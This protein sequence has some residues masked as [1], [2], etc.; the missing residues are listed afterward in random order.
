MAVLWSVDVSANNGQTRFDVIVE[1][2]S[3]ESAEQ[4]AV[5]AV[6]QTGGQDAVA[7]RSRRFSDGPD[8]ALDARLLTA[9]LQA[10]K[11]GWAILGTAPGNRV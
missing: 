11:Q 5:R 7:M 8:D 10:R 6:S 2:A 9:V 1:D 3:R 4:T